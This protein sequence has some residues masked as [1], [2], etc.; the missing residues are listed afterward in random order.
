MSFD[1]KNVNKSKSNT[2]IHLAFQLAIIS[3]VIPLSVTSEYMQITHST[4]FTVDA[5]KMARH[6]RGIP[7]SSL[8][9][10]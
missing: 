3:R 7:T 5:L 10:C 2:K 4:E 6:Y 9:P 1:I 8:N